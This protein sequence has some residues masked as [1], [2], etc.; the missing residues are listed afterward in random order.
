MMGR[1][2]RLVIFAVV[3]AAAP[4][5]FLWSQNSSLSFQHLSSQ[6]GLTEN[7]ANSFVFK[8]SRGYAWI[9]SLGG[10]YRFDGIQIKLYPPDPAI[11]GSLQEG[12]VQ[13]NFF[14]DS[15]G[16]L[17]FSTYTGIHRYLRRTD[18]FERVEMRSVDREMPA[19]QYHAFF[20]ESDSLLWFA[21]DSII[22]TY[23][24]QTEQASY[25]CSTIG[26]RFGVDV[27]EQG[28]LRRIVECPWNVHAGI[29][30][31][32]LNERRRPKQHIVE[33]FSGVG[34]MEPVYVSDAA[35][36]DEGIIWL[37][38]N[39]GLIR[40]NRNAPNP[41]QHFP[42]SASATS[43]FRH[44]AIQDPNTLL[45]SGASGIWQ[46]D[47]KRE[48]FIQN[49]KHDPSDP[50]SL[51]QYLVQEL[52][53]D[54][55]NTLWVSVYNR[56]VDYASFHRNRFDNPAKHLANPA[57]LVSALAEDKYGR[58]WCNV[59]RQGLFVYDKE[60]KSAKKYEV[61]KQQGAQSLSGEVQ[62][63]YADNQGDIWVI[64]SNRLYLFIPETDQFSQ[65]GNVPSSSEYNIVQVKDKHYLSTVNKLMEVY[66]KNDFREEGMREVFLDGIKPDEYVKIISIPSADALYVH[67][68][69]SIKEFLPRGE[70]LILGQKLAFPYF[71]YDVSSQRNNE[72]V[73]I[74]TNAGVFIWYPKS[75]QLSKLP[76]GGLRFREGCSCAT[77]DDSGRIWAALGTNIERLD[78]KGPASLTFYPEDGI[79]AGS[80]QLGVCLSASDGKLWFGG[81]N[82]LAVFLPD[83][84]IPYPYPPSPHLASFAV[85]S[86]PYK[87]NLY[88]DEAEYLEFAYNENNFSLELRAAGYHLPR[89]SRIRYR[90]LG[91]D[92]AWQIAENGATIR[93]NQ[94]PPKKYYLELIAINANGI[95]SEPKVLCLIIHPPFWQ[96][97][98][99]VLLVFVALVSFGYAIYAY[100]LNQL[101][102]EWGFRQK[103]LIS[104]MKALRAQMN[105]HFI[106]NALNSIKALVLR[107]E[108]QKADHALGRF[109]DLMRQM[110][111]NSSQETV[112]LER[113]IEFLEHYLAVEAMRF[114][115][116]FDWSIM[117]AED[118]DDYEV[119]IPTMILQ[120]FVENAIVHGI[121]PKPEGGKLVIDIAQDGPSLRCRIEDDGIGRAAAAKRKSSAA[122][123][124][125]SQGIAITLERLALY[126]QKNGLCSSCQTNDLFGADGQPAG[127][128]VIIH[129]GIKHESSNH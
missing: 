109:A 105:P 53:L 25:V 129:I 83:D 51:S 33:R 48:R 58:I 46:F 23:N 47:K 93:Y 35:V 101:K 17:W 62:L 5:S 116:P 82:G 104:E 123:H 77:F 76:A 113:E 13:S 42:L 74:N 16:D 44:L 14:E 88:F 84:V 87:G 1:L 19:A 59:T 24:L 18:R 31:I 2:K 12:L 6:D 70:N 108:N 103:N 126:D 106:F 11:E 111:D 94:L 27:D 107:Q 100:R 91:Y 124:H 127:T 57:F 110:L 69:D 86:I 36:D 114:N 92:D 125:Q 85:N 9:S 52:F 49:W 22:F 10:V 120:P 117:V 71:I 112:P 26:R 128:Q 95:E 61:S 60:G 68:N 75:F 118:V 72:E 34:G 64:S 121:M 67:S 98:W 38:S 122:K 56:G 78:P 65:I 45:L 43:G 21:A 97:W 39:F 99:F 3:A 50:G 119:Q 8:D 37:C 20:L 79:S 15:K 102:K 73:L 89:L 63:L 7:R 29:G 40:F 4:L 66:P 90:L 30:V 115:Q 41:Y 81:G 80:F 54:Q 28:V 96:R 55:S 32:D